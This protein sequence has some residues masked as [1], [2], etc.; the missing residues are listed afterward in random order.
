MHINHRTVG[1]CLLAFCGPLKAE[2][3]DIR[4]DPVIFPVGPFEFAPIF[5]AAESYNDNIFQQDRFKK[6]SF[7]TQFHAGGQLALERHLNRYALT[8]TLQ[9]SQY[10]NSPQDD[11]VDHFVGGSSHI[12]FTSRNRLD[13]NLGY[14]DSHY[15]RGI[16]LG[17]DLIN[18]TGQVGSDSL[19]ATGRS[20]PDQYHLHSADV[21]YRY[22]RVEAKG[23]LEL[24]FNVQ[25][26]TF[27]NNREFTARQDRTQF[28]VM[29]GFYFRIAPKTTLQTQIE[30]TLVKHRQDEASE[31][32][33][34][35]HRFLV[36]GTWR[37]SVKTQ[38][39]ARIGYLHQE[40]DNST[41]TS[42]DD[43]T[44]DLS[45][46]WAP[47]SYS[48]LNLAIA[49]DATP[50]I[51]SDNVRASDR[52]RLSWA[53]DWTSRVTTQLFGARENA[54]NL[55]VNRQ[56]DYTSVG[57]DLNYGVRRWLGIGINYSYRNLSSSSSEFDFNQNAIMF[58]I[59]G[60][61]RISDD[62]KTPWASWY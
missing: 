42:F 55:G 52:F 21:T 12:E 32:D 17:R 1:W 11:Y 8:Y 31:F 22:G 33:Y 25:D 37:Y 24:K 48:R 9:S 56:D 15:Q 7:L 58:Y 44:W 5:E 18:P 57:F 46:S 20:E 28:I 10:H 43:V 40:F 45:M 3:L 62:A 59:T 49:R 35:K 2:V 51:A 26:Y 14:L 38:F 36:G 50:S 34:S 19:N 60:N 39:G 47:L 13:V 29:P 6:G 23:N 4:K 30:N 54:E 16:F 41:S 61:P 27:Q 53:H